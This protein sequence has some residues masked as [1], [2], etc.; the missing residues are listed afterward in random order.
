MSERWEVQNTQTMSAKQKCQKYYTREC[1]LCE[2]FNCYDNV[3]IPG[4]KAE[5][6]RLRTENKSLNLQIGFLKTKNNSLEFGAEK[7]RE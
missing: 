5:V 2:D 6:R 7:A 3:N 4:M 1:H